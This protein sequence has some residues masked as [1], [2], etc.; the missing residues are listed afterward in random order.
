MSFATQAIDFIAFLSY[1]TT[2]QGGR[3]T[4]VFNSGYRPQNKFEFSEMQ[5]SGEQRILNKEIVYP[6][7][8]VEAEI[9]LLTTDFLENRLTE[10]MNFE[11]R[12][13]SKIIGTGE[14]K[15]IINERLKKASR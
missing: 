11:F 6:G 5:T 13:G 8:K 15:T 3:S 12:E 2:E 9:K 4:P 1:C 7:D 14:I 10:G